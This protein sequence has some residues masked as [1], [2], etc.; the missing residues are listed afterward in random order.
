MAEFK[1]ILSGGGGGGGPSLPPWAQDP[2]TGRALTPAYAG[3][4]GY[5]ARQTRQEGF[6]AQA[7]FGLKEAFAGGPISA[8]QKQAGLVGLGGVGGAFG[9]I[10]AAS[11]A[12][13]PIGGAL[14]GANES[15]KLLADGINEAAKHVRLFGDIV[16]SIAG[17]D[18]MGAFQKGLEGTAGTLE[19]IPLIGQVLGAELRLAG[20]VV[21][22]FTT[23]VKAFVERGEE[24]AKYSGAVAGARATAA[25]RGILGDVREAQVLGADTARLT[26]AQSRFYEE[27][28]EIMLPIKRF[29]L[30]RLAV[31]MDN[32][33]TFLEFVGPLLTAIQEA[34]VGLLTIAGQLG[35]GQFVAALETSS[36]TL[37]RI[38]AAVEKK[39]DPATDLMHRFYDVFG[40]K[41]NMGAD[42]PADPMRMQARQAA[43]VPALD[44]GG[45]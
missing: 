31:V 19:K 44:G 4:Y 34:N 39:R 5:R 29:L 33:A 11:A 12:F 9:N 27:F 25:V 42:A 38:L 30:E 14:A 36:V 10:G 3:S 45:A 20:A 23:I 17:N 1:I 41:P 2:E 13:G 24:L 37:K 35:T 40:G 16:G 43:N 15:G 7:M 6:F 18:Y 8:L 26:D 21:G 22:S 32:L 28:R